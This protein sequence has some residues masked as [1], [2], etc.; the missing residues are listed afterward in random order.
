MDPFVGTG[1]FI[2]R[3]MRE[4]K[5]TAL[6]HKYAHELHCN[7]VLL[8][9]YYIAAMNIEH[10]YY[11]LTNNYQ[12]FE[13]ICLVDTFELAED[14]QISLFT[15]VNTERVERQKKSPIFVILGNPPYNTGQVNENDNN[16]N[17][18]YPVVDKRVSETYA[19]DSKAS[20]KNALSDVYVKAIRWAADRIKGDGIITFVSNNSFVDDFAFDGMR[21]HLG[22]D[23][24]RIYVLDLKGNIR[25]DS[26]KD[27]IPLG[28]KHTVFGLSAMV[29]VSITFLI[30]GSHFADNK[31]F[32][33]S[34][35]FRATRI[36]KF[37]FL[38]K[39]NVLQNL[40][41]TE[42]TPDARFT[43]LTEGLSKDFESLIPMATKEGRRGTKSNV[44]FTNFSNGVKT[45]RDT[46]VY[47]QKLE[48]V[49]NNVRRMIDY[50]N[51]QVH[52][53]LA[54]SKKPNV[55]DFVHYDDSKI[56]WSRDLKLDLKR[57]RLAEFD[58]T[59]IRVS[60]Y[61]PFTK[62]Y[63]FFDP[64]VNEEVYQ[65]PRIY[66]TAEKEKEN[67][68]IC[69]PSPG[70]KNVAFFISNRIP[71]LN[72]F[73]GSAPI[74]CLPFYTYGEDGSNRRVNL[75]D[76]AL[77]QFQKQY[78]DQMISKWDIF[79]YIYAV[80][81]HP[82]YRE[83]YAANL[84]RELP[85]IPFAPKFWPFAEAGK[86]LAELHVQYENQPEYP[87]QKIESE[88]QPLNWQVEKMKLSK[89]KIQ[90]IYNDFLIL[91]GIPEE[92]FEYRLGNRSALDWIVDQYRVKTDKR[93]GIVNDPN[94]E[95]DP[96]Y[97]VR[98]IGQVITVSL[99]TVKIVKSLPDLE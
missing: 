27:G 13:G 71:D 78:Q 96:Q 91:A 54:H 85:R 61:R 28:E 30:K 74:Q 10:E 65:Y 64:I 32:Y 77:A 6:P 98:L 66:P 57:G 42:I 5:K 4:I 81:H 39:Q 16:K 25:K 75:T 8:L 86:K 31:I 82:L 50:Y 69:V 89:D 51:D 33:K 90:I 59:K 3:V 94:R 73:G 95:D 63:L 55:D 53:W 29:G 67:I 37:S 43:W 84:R 93:S 26:M 17:R 18:K 97:I 2:L 1:N 48:A 14:R 34:V 35:D 46:W 47:N 80:L 76:W 60:M 44:L 99:E 9:P 58:N 23:F 40:D 12:P 88:D 7:E 24:N 15:T 22:K 41:L 20:N 56:S 79:Y 45:N 62:E 38:E 72:F 83:K 19:T 87:L 68:V 49:S 52:K 92:T 36:D 11:E 70:S 21:K